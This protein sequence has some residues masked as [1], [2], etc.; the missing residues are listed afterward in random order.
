M[1]NLSSTTAHIDIQ[2]PEY[3]TLQLALAPKEV[4]YTLFDI[5]EENS[6][7]SGSLPL[8]LSGG[9]YLKAVENAIYDNPVLLNDYRQ[10]RVLV[11][12]QHFMILPAEFSDELDAQDAFEAMYAD[13]EGDFALCTLPRC[14]VNI[15]YEV[16][17][18]VLGFLRR[19]FNMPPIVHHL[20]PLMEHFKLQDERRTGA[21]LHLNLR[22]EG[23]D[24]L[25]IRDRE[26]VMANSFPCTV[27][28]DAIYYTLNAWQN[29][30]L[31][32]TKNEL[33]VTGSKALRDATIP[34]LR[35]YINYVMPSI[36]PAAAL[37]IG[38][39]AVKA[40]LSLILLALCE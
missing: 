18:G 17:K 5:D 3:W 2:R 35:K 20:Y 26:L 8:D 21:C 34:T 12:S 29:F 6:L 22:E 15:G 4:Q 9:S 33:F 25:I 1:S 23:I 30:G 31:D 16:P 19:T 36:F 37:R 11:Q 24:I 7:I 27:T 28:A 10:V 13:A 38:Q 40:P 14:G 39:D 32:A